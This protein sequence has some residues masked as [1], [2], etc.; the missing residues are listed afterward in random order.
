MRQVLAQRLA[1]LKFPQAR[2]TTLGIVA[3]M[4]FL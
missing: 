1:I 2:V 3:A 4:A